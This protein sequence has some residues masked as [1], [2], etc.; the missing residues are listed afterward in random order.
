MNFADLYGGK[1]LLGN[2]LRRNRRFG[3]GGNAEV[4]VDEV[5]G[6]VVFVVVMKSCMEWDVPRELHHRVGVEEEGKVVEIA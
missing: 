1:L 4:E 6:L 5:G 3:E 2:I